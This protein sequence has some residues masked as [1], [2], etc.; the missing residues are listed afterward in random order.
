[1]LLQPL[2]WR[3]IENVTHHERDVRKKQHTNIYNND[4]LLRTHGPY[5]RHK[6]TKSG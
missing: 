4:I 5:H 3:C 1:M 6:N 2:S